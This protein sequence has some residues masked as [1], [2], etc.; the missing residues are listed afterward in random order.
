MNTTTTTWPGSSI[1]QPAIERPIAMRLAE[2]EYQRVTDAVD[3]LQLEDW[4]RPTDC[5]EWDVRRSPS[6]YPARWRSAR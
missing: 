6:V 5:T 3:A 2:T 1:V 4:S